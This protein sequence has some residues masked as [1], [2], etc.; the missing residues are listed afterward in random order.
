[1]ATFFVGMAGMIAKAEALDE[2]IEKGIDANLARFES[3]AESR[4]K[5]NAPW[6]DRTG[7]ARNGLAA[8]SGSEGDV[9]VL[10]LY[11]QVPYQI[12]LEVKNSGEYAIIWPTV[13]EIGPE[14]MESM[15]GLMNALGAVA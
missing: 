3:I 10:V 12:F 6:T 8:S 5:D 2:T 11:G 7:N 4:M 15:N 13:Q 9:H 1:M 14:V